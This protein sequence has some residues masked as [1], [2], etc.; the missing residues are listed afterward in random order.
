MNFQTVK[1]NLVTILG[2]GASGRYRTIGYQ[3]QGDSTELTANLNRSVQV[4]YAR[5]SFPKS[6]AGIRGPIRHEMSFRIEL[7]ASKAARVDLAALESF[8]STPAQKATALAGLQHAASLAD[9]S[10]DELMSIVYGV[11][12]DNS[13]MDLGPDLE[14]SSRW[15][16][17]YSK[18]APHPRGSLV[19]VTGSMDL[20][21]TIYETLSGLE[22]LNVDSEGVIQPTT[23]SVD[24]VNDDDELTLQGV[25]VTN[26]APE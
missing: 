1:D 15:I 16:S 2:A 17:S 7:L 6:G 4:F 19:T 24:V 22:A 5:G 26:A 21:G 18:D 8:V 25:T 3:P 23:I 20:T 13:D 9:D 11:L 12:M 10:A 14:V